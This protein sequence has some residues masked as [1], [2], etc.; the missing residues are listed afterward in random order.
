ML[1]RVLHDHLHVV[2]RIR[3]QPGGPRI[4]STFFGPSQIPLWLRSTTRHDFS[5]CFKACVRFAAQASQGA[6][7]VLEGVAEK[8]GAAVHVIKFLTFCAW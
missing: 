7:D 4:E 3:D 6:L 1:L 5:N 8:G 2:G